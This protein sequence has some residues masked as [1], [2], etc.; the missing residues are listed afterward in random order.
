MLIGCFADGL[1]GPVLLLRDPTE[2]NGVRKPARRI[3]ES[4]GRDVFVAR[5]R[6]LNA[7]LIFI[8]SNH[9]LG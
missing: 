4:T 5:L 6:E 1:Q 7:S 8:H 3:R 2:S 9:L